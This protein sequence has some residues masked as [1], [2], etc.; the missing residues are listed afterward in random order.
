[1]VHR[2]TL[3]HV[4]RH[5][6]RAPEDAIRTA[7]EHRSH[8]AAGRSEPQVAKERQLAVFNRSARMKLAKERRIHRGRITRAGVRLHRVA[9]HRQT[10]A[11]R[12]L[13]RGG[14]HRTPGG[15]VHRASGSLRVRV[16]VAGDGLVQLHARLRD[17]VHRAQIR[18][19][20]HD[21]MD[22]LHV[23]RQR[24]QRW[25]IDDGHGISRVD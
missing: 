9:V 2:W 12:R 24:R 22:E 14:G 7:L 15:C 10:T 18:D 20:E 13:A 25:H 23:P 17:E 8:R 5:S 1:M 4:C 3:V 19:A 11:P 16:D 21:V 6:K